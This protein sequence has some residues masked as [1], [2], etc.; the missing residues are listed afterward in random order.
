MASRG[1]DIAGVKHVVNFN[2]PNSLR[3]YVHRVGR[4][5][6]AGREGRS[7]SF[8]GEGNEKK[9][10][11]EILAKCSNMGYLKSFMCFFTHFDV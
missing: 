10:L 6:R 5:A 1:L 3:Q 9:L 7:I 2:M 11:K 8:V 4:T